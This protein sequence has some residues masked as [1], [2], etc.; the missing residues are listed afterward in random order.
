MNKIYRVLWNSARGCWA[1]VSEAAG[2]TQ[3]RESGSTQGGGRLR[4]IDVSVRAGKQKIATA[5][6][7]KAIAGFCILGTGL[8]SVNAAG[9]SYSSI[10]GYT[11]TLQY[12]PGEVFIPGNWS[13]DEPLDNW[14]YITSPDTGYGYGTVT[15]YFTGL[16]NR[17]LWKSLASGGGTG[18]FAHDYYG[19]VNFTGGP[20]AG[21]YVFAKLAAGSGSTATIENQSTGTIIL[22]TPLDGT[23]AVIGTMSDEGASASIINS[24]KGKMTIW[25][26]AIS[27]TG[28]G[29]NTIE[30]TGEG[31]LTVG[32]FSNIDN[33]VYRGSDTGTQALDGN[34]S[35]NA[36]G[37][38]EITGGTWSV[39]PR[40]MYHGEEREF[41]SV[42]PLAADPVPV[43]WYEGQHSFNVAGTMTNNATLNI[44]ASRGVGANNGFIDLGWDDP[45]L[46]VKTDYNGTV[47]A[48]DG[49][50]FI[51]DQSGRLINNRSIKVTLRAD[52][53]WGSDFKTFGI[54]NH[55]VV[56]NNGTIAFESLLTVGYG[57]QDHGTELRGLFAFSDG[58]WIAPAASFVDMTLV[59]AQASSNAPIIGADGSASSSD[60]FQG[61]GGDGIHLADAAVQ[62]WVS[63]SI[64]AGSIQFTDETLTEASQTIIR[65]ALIEAGVTSTISFAGTAVSEPVYSNDN[66]NNFLQ[67][68]SNAGAVLPEADLDN[69]GASFKVGFEDGI[70]DSIGVRKVDNASDITVAAGKKFTLL[71]DGTTATTAPIALASGSTLE[72]GHTSNAITEAQGGFVGAITN[73]GTLS[74]KKGSFNTPSVT[75]SGSVSVDTAAAL[76]TERI[77]GSSFTSGGLVQTKQIESSSVTVEQ[78]STLVAEKLGDQTAQQIELAGTTIV[79][80][81]SNKGMV[82]MESG[83]TL[84]VGGAN[85][86]QYLKRYPEVAKIIYEGG[87]TI[88][89]S[90]R[91]MLIDKGLIVEAASLAEE[92]AAGAAEDVVNIGSGT[93]VASQQPVATEQNEPDVENEQTEATPI[94]AAEPVMNRTRT[95]PISAANAALR[96]GT[97]YEAFRMTEAAH[98]TA[99]AHT[100]SARPADATLWASGVYS[101]TKTDD[102]DSDT[103]GFTMGADGNVGKSRFG[104]AFTYQKGDVDPTE[105]SADTEQFAF[106]LYGSTTFANDMTAAYGL[107][108]AKG[109]NEVSSL[110]WSGKA[111]NDS[112][113][114]GLRISKPFMFGKS[115]TVAPYMGIDAVYLKGK[116]FELNHEQSDPFTVG[117]TDELI[118][119][120]PVGVKLGKFF[121]KPDGTLNTSLDLSVTPQFGGRNASRVIEGTSFTETLGDNYIGAAKLGVSYQNKRGS[122]SLTYEGSKG[123]IRNLSHSVQA[124]ASVSF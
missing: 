107:T 74:V 53:I 72:L 12:N 63:K 16:S 83:A 13:S 64:F 96:S 60:I 119:R 91:Q 26:Y 35:V 92:P 120:L 57:G 1:A 76:I 87:G 33:L 51:I 11:A 41:G 89:E 40:F 67:N 124:K 24:G 116:G 93:Y 28:K 31:T 45:G 98:E 114:A 97:L 105:G 8:G 69:G 2:T 102:F 108:Y 27:S 106:T 73:N 65:N 47:D 39:R 121:A 99:L 58:V 50:G 68:A 78:G 7:M 61:S 22:N 113:A 80:S 32:A 36:G 21:D 117:K 15:F 46:F 112:L 52:A 19:K 62:D 42:V 56:E 10:G 44:S 14:N 17:G 79:E 81:L 55:G 115:Y 23:E 103:T 38:L 5:A 118:G 25:A 48:A 43:G 123:N 100:M 34:Q 111:K 29:Q 94:F 122:F 109:T 90:I 101:K 104:A 82:S 110:G 37:S 75:G 49:Y 20:S 18:S 6:L 95:I 54:I 70:K 85:A 71:G 86:M 88:P 30:N 9:D 59:E 3:S 77:T 84:V 66:I 4:R